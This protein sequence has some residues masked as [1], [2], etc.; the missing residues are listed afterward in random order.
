M[1]STNEEPSSGESSSSDAESPDLQR[2]T[3]QDTLEIAQVESIVLSVNS[4]GGL[5]REPSATVMPAKH[6]HEARNLLL[7][8]V[9]FAV[10]FAF[11]S[12][13]VIVLP[14]LSKEL[15][16]QEL[17]AQ[18]HSPLYQLPL[19]LWFLMDLLLSTPNAMFMQRYGRRAGFMMGAS[20]ALLASVAVFFVL[21]CLSAH[22][23][24]AYALLNCCVVPMSFIGVSEFVRYAASE[25]CADASRKGK[26]VSRVITGGAVISVVGPLATSA[27]SVIDPGNPVIGNSYFF[28]CMAVLAAIA[29]A[30]AHLLKLPTPGTDAASAV[31]PLCQIL[32]RTSVWTSILAQLAVQFAM[33]TPMNAIPLHMDDELCPSD[34]LCSVR[35]HLIIVFCIISHVLAMFLPGLWTGNFIAWR[36]LFPVMISGLILQAASITVNLSSPGIISNYIGLTLL[37]VGWNFA[38]VAGT[39][40]LLASHSAEERAKVTGV[41]ETLRFTANA[42]AGLLS[43]SL[44]WTTINCVCLGAVVLSAVVLVVNKTTPKAD[45]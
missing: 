40:L 33:V 42:V 18:T 3:D 27:G 17:G 21:R 38:F 30:S 2:D 39:M 1:S 9:Y 7:L 23:L 5:A 20:C 11:R 45:S 29:L 34:T 28:L 31:M 43:S 25:A 8:S 44:P 32:R 36:G 4:F 15:L 35:Q 41:N 12:G 26:A 10:Y 37:G 24:V 22:K 19:A 14:L 6:Q 13:T 16:F